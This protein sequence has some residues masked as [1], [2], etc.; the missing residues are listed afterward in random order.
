MAIGQQ[1]QEALRIEQALKS[2]VALKNAYFW[3]TECTLTKDEQDP[4]TP[5]KPFPDKLYLKMT[6]DYLNQEPSPVKWI[7]KSRTMLASWAVSAW[8]GH[9]GFTHP[10]TCVAFQSRDERRALKCV[11]YV[12]ELWKNSLEPLRAGWP[13]AKSLERQPDHSLELANGSKFLALTGD[14]DNIRSE[15]PTIVVLDEAAFMERGEESYNTALATQC[16]HMIVLS[17]ANSGWFEDLI[18]QA[19]PVPWPYSLEAA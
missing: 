5:Y 9:H 15:H 6:F 4:E 19:R 1:L 16:L 14:P 11:E 12:K 17:S 3:A 18:E 7:K 2:R 13:L 10:A 8:S